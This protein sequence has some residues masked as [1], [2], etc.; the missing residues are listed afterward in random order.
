MFRDINDDNWTYNI[1]ARAQLYLVQLK[2]LSF[3][4][5]FLFGY[6]CQMNGNNNE[7]GYMFVS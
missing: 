6:N 4:Q 7:I 1:E 3:Q 5:C 2:R